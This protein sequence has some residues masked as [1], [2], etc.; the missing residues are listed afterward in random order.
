[1][2]VSTNHSS[3]RSASRRFDSLPILLR[4]V[5]RS[6]RKSISGR[7]RNTTSTTSCRDPTRCRR[8]TFKY[9]TV[10]G[11]DHESMRSWLVRFSC[12]PLSSER[13]ARVKRSC[14]TVGRDIIGACRHSFVGPMLHFH[15]ACVLAVSILGGGEGSSGSE[16]TYGLVHVLGPIAHY[17]ASELLAPIELLS[18]VGA[19][20]KGT[21]LTRSSRPVA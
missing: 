15:S 17:P 2:L 9:P 21:F 1:M 20:R 5:T 4:G 6:P 19:Q 16:P 10:K 12:V 11:L 8:P 13:A 3:W 14:P 7:C 18:P